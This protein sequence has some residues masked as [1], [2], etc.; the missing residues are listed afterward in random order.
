MTITKERMEEIRQD[1]VTAL[2]KYDIPFQTQDA[3]MDWV[4]LHRAPGHFLTAVLEND[5]VGAFGRA[6]DGNKR[7]LEAIIKVLYNHVPNAC[8]GSEDN[9]REWIEEGVQIQLKEEAV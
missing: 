8:W 6:D 9:V 2:G 4:M 3:L 1:M 5:L 7:A